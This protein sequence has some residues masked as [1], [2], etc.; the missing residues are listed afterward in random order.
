M[1]IVFFKFQDI[2]YHALAASALAAFSIF[3]IIGL[4]KL[5]RG[6]LTNT[7]NNIFGPYLP[8]L[9]TYRYGELSPGEAKIAGVSFIELKEVLATIFKKY[10]KLFY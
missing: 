10:L 1:T 7:S 6:D 5:C 8:P 3:F 4:E 2:I 9:N